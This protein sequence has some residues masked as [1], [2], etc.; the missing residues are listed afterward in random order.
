MGECLADS[1]ADLEETSGWLLGQLAEHRDVALAGAVPYGRIFAN[2][3]GGVFL[4][5]G[6][7]AAARGAGPG[8]R[9]AHVALARHFAETQ[10]PLTGGLK[11]AVYNAHETVLGS[12]G[13]AV[14]G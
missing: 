2:T 13:D 12:A 5:R 14:L 3:A 6:A 7:L 11:R 10:A 4:A 9:T 8:D 1:V